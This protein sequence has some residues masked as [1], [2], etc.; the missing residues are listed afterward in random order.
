MTSS[1]IDHVNRPPRPL[2]RVS[3]SFVGIA[4]FCLIVGDVEISTLD[5]WGEMARMVK[6]VFTPDFF[7]TEHLG[8][9]IL[10]TLSFAFIGVVL[11][12]ACGFA[13]SLI[14]RYPAVRFFCAF[15]RAVHELFWAL[16]FLQ[17]FGLTPITGILA[18]A[19][20]FA[21]AFAKVYSEIIEEAD[22]SPLK[23]IPKGSGYVSTLFYARIPDIWTHFK[24]YTM[25]R[26][27]CGLRSS[28]V[29]GFVGLPTIGFHLETAFSNGNYSEVSALLYLFF[30]IIASMRL[31]MRPR[32]LPAYLLGAFIVLPVGA[33]ISMTNVTRFL[34]QDII[35]GPLRWVNTIDGN[36]L[37]SLGHWAWN[38]LYREALPGVVNTVL[39]TMIALVGAGILT[40]VFFPLISKK[41]FGRRRRAVGHIFL[42][43][44]RSTPEYILAYVFLQLWGPSML[45]AIVALSLHNGAIIGHLIGRYADELPLRPDAPKGMNLYTYNIVPRVYGQFMAFLFYRWEVIMRETAILGILG[46]KTLGFY[47]DS[48]FTDIR[49]DRALALIIITALL[50]IAVDHISRIVRARLRLKTNPDIV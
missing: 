23:T 4:V 7:A 16:I 50:N 17:A 5:P 14:F 25:Y 12:S 44:V 26:M 31:W 40:L 49:F 35:P 30:I 43:V 10:N 36:A 38:L 46:I 39:L 6:G 47:V 18:I 21:G 42:V 28:A 8:G 15:I 9:A 11:G 32:L 29:L 13:L 19:I 1:T 45:P 20:P 34:T 22:A 3:L 27:E 2:A 41:F 37:D 24:T 33:D 48:A